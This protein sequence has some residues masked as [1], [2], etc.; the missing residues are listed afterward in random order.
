MIGPDGLLV[1]IE[2]TGTP[3]A[4]PVKTKVEQGLTS[5]GWRI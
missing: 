1:D 3:V 5:M 2:V 4:P